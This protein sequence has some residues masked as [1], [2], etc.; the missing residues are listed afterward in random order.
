MTEENF[1]DVV[2]ITSI[3]KHSKTTSLAEALRQV[4]TPALHDAGFDSLLLKKL[5]NEL[6]G[7]KATSSLIEEETY[8]RDRSTSARS[9]E[10]K[11]LHERAAVYLKNIRREMESAAVA[12]LALL[13]SSM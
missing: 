2:Q 10:E 1:H 8:M 9:S 6:L 3:S 12:R 4:W 13:F 7:P 5:E 11:K